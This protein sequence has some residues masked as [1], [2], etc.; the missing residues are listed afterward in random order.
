MQGCALFVDQGLSPAWY[1]DDDGNKLTLGAPNLIAEPFASLKVS[2]IHLDSLLHVLSERYGNDACAGQ[3]DA[4]LEEALGRARSMYPKTSNSVGCVLFPA[5]KIMDSISTSLEHESFAAIETIQELDRTLKHSVSR[6]ITL[7]ETARLALTRGEKLNVKVV[8]ELQAMQSRPDGEWQES[9]Q[10]DVAPVFVGGKQMQEL[11][12]SAYGEKQV[13]AGWIK[14]WA[15]VLLRLT[16]VSPL[17][18]EM[19]AGSGLDLESVSCLCAALLTASSVLHPNAP[20]CTLPIAY[21]Y[22]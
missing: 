22:G 10:W 16:S 8:K 11:L 6:G 7:V 2:E 12:P 5:D 4:V 21:W 19:G 3:L 20:S 18:A 1:V 14:S 15:S 17:S 9:R 13:G